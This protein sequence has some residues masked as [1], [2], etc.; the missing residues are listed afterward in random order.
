MRK[1][2]SSTRCTGEALREAERAAAVACQAY[3]DRVVRPRSLNAGR[4]RLASALSDLYTHRLGLPFSAAYVDELATKLR[5]P[6]TVLVEMAHD[7]QLPHLGIVRLVLKAREIASLVP[8]GLAVYFVGDHYTAAMRPENLYVGMP[9]RGRDADHVKNP[10]TIPIGRKARHVPFRWLPPPRVESLEEL[11]RRV[12]AWLVNNASASQKRGAVPAIREQVA[13]RFAMLRESSA[14]TSSFG[15]WLMRIQALLFRDLFGGPPPNLAILPMGD[16]GT[17]VPEVVDDLMA[18]DAMVA[19]IK[20]DISAEQRGRGETPYAGEPMEMSSFWVHC[21][22]CHRRSRASISGREFRTT[23]T[24]CGRSVVARWPEDAALV[25]PDIVAYELALFRTGISGW[26]VGSR[27]PYHAVIERAYESLYGIPM[28]PK[29]FLT[30]IPRFQGIGEP[31]EGHP[32]AR[33]LRV[34]VEMDPAR[35]R[36]ALEAP[37]EENPA[38]TSPHLA[39]S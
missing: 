31:K 5:D 18:R 35:V 6:E 7:G 24:S 39:V 20:R 26:V 4:E 29:F 8:R 13:A 28:P 10:L 27:A 25:L 36:A 32:R 9:L 14:R 33:L 15:D 21:P 37:W 1:G 16:I 11:E 34:L 17:W 3:L 23:C 38:L 12:D 30:S 2:S 22:E 19:Q